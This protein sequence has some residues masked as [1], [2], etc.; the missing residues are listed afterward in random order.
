MSCLPGGKKVGWK[1]YVR[2]CRSRSIIVVWDVILVCIDED[3]VPGKY[4]DQRGHWGEFCLSWKDI[5]RGQSCWNPDHSWSRPVHRVDTAKQ[6]RFSSP[7]FRRIHSAE[8]SSDQL[9]PAH[10][11]SDLHVP[12]WQTV[13]SVG[14]CV[15]FCKTGFWINLNCACSLRIPRHCLFCWVLD[16]LVAA[17]PFIIWSSLRLDGLVMVLSMLCHSSQMV[18]FQ[19]MRSFIVVSW[20]I[21]RESRC[22]DRQPPMLF[23]K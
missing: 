5:W 3:T 6:K 2:T 23:A 13:G 11:P 22:L 12:A 19:A 10:P 16:F 20:A 17:R 21:S 14:Q 9:L 7:D 4:K 15:R 18:S 8:S 1:I